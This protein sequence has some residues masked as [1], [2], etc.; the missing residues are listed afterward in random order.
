MI[1]F[2]LC[3]ALVP[4]IALADVN[5]RACPDGVPTPESLTVNNCTESSCV[6]V[7]GEPLYALAS[8][9]VSPVDSDT[10]T[11]YVVVRVDELEV[12]YQIPRDQVDACTGGIIGGCPIVAG[13]PFNYAV[14][15][16]E[17]VIPANDFQVEIEFG[18]I[19]EGG[20]K[21]GC[22]RFDA[23]VQ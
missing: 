5:F 2:L 6:L 14:A 9:I 17:L 3:V 22:V 18:L 13:T 11:A 7:P 16:D 20:V 23:Y 15:Y 1:K 10:A 4:A 21:L 19:G 12:V 8:G